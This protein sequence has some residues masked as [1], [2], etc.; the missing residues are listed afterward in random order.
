LGFLL[1]CALMI[2]YYRV[3][4]IISVA[5]LLINLILLI[6]CLS[7]LGATMTMPGIAGIVLTLGMS[8]DGNVL[9]CE[10]IREELRLGNSPVS[11]IKTG[12]ERAWT[13]ILDANVAKVISALALFS[14]GSGP[15]R[16]FALVLLF[17]VVTSVFTSVTVSRALSTL[18]YGHNR[19][20]KRISVGGGF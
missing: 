8:I 17:G 1:V 15:V 4:G 5:A 16:G 2:V 10:R 19:K 7:V 12:Y 11:S 20:V 14:F 18:V 9:I 13:V 6:A 3:F